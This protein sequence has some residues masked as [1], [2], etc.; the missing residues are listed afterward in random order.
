MVN[1]LSEAI[2]SRYGVTVNPEDIKEGKDGYYVARIKDGY[3]MAK[4]KNSLGSWK[5]L[6]AKA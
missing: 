3:I 1:N 4:P 5:F 2:Q 6:I